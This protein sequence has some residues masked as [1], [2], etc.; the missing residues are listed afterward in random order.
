MS[1]AWFGQLERGSRP[2]MKIIAWIALKLGRAPARLLLYPITAYA[3]ITGGQARRA[4]RAY[5][6]RSLGRAPRFTEIARHFHTY[7]VTILDRVFFLV[8]QDRYFDVELHNPGTLLAQLRGGR[9]CILLGSHLGSFEAMRALAIGRE[10]LPLKILMY[11]HQN[12]RLTEVLH[13]LNAA[14]ENSVI[15]LGGPAA[16]FKVQEALQGG[17]IV[18]L[19]GD[20]VAESDKS[21]VCNFLGEPARFP[22]GPALMAALFKVPVVLGF[23]LYR[24]A[25]RYDVHFELLS[26]GVP[27]DG[28][29]NEGNLQQWMGRYVERLEYFTRLAPY[30]WF[31]FY[32]FW[33]DEA[34]ESE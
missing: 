26:E 12:R 24:G 31:N 2:A 29:R 7:S 25:N 20:R 21:V 11:P 6:Q 27:I 15:A 16:M 3:L 32:D 18:G 22:A 13:G 34:I 9:G 14:A 23:A 1:R 10:R 5:L 17:A 4:S 19:L 33:N 28:A 8:G 30:N